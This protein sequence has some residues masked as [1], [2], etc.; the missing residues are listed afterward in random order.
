MLK[1]IADELNQFMQC[2]GYRHVT[3]RPVIEAQTD[4]TVRDEGTAAHAAAHAIF[5]NAATLEQLINTKH[6]NGV[7][8]T[9][10]LL[11]H[12]GEYLSALDCGETEANTTLEIEG[13]AIIAARC[14]H[15]S[16]SADGRVLTI[17][18]LKMGYGVRTPAMNWTLIHHA[19][20]TC[21]E[22]NV[23]PEY[24]SLRIHQ[25]RAF[26]PL[27]PL[28]SWVIS[29]DDLLGYYGQ[30]VDKIRRD[31]PTLN[32]GDACLKCRK[33][34]NCP[35]NREMVG[36]C[37][38]VAHELT[39][40]NLS[41]DALSSELDLLKVAKERISSRL[42]SLEG[43]ARHEIDAGH[44]VPNYSVEQGEGQRRWISG[45]T[46]EGLSAMTGKDLYEKPKTVTPAEAVRRGVPDH[47]VKSLSERPNTGLKLV[48]ITA[49]DRM[50]NAKRKSQNV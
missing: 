14:D 35:A 29:Y 37:V 36:N 46:A 11:T 25:P 24:V 19:Y 45:L 33:R 17:D 32:T 18:D 9:E 27:G 47:I 4:T 10:Q 7:V 22:W 40:D 28:R 44:V 34:N 13:V 31:D 49:T 42:E 16:L 48:R 2:D 26:H 5:T 1:L 50:N 15:R 39:D 23:R 21:V 43:T 38:D 3:E 12:V 8:L 20:S 41:N 30:L 6:T